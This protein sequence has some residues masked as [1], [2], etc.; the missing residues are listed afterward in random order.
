MLN[1]YSVSL[2]SVIGGGQSFS[3]GILAVRPK[4]ANH[5]KMQGIMVPRHE[6]DASGLV[7]DWI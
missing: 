6:T 3:S 5:L 4:N 7:R 2:G 1:S